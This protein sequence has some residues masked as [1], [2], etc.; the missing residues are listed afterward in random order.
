M[1]KHSKKDSTP[2]Q[3]QSN[4]YSHVFFALSD[5]YPDIAPDI[6]AV[7]P[8]N[9][10]LLELE[11]LLLKLSEDMIGDAMLYNLIEE[12]KKWAAENKLP[13]DSETTVQSQPSVCKFF[14]QGRCKF[15]EK[16]KNAHPST[17]N[18]ELSSNLQVVKETTPSG[19]GLGNNVTKEPKS[20]KKSPMKTASD[21]ISRIQWDDRIDASSFSI[22][23]LDRLD[24]YRE[25]EGGGGGV[26]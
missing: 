8:S 23:Y 3:S 12:A 14:L 11:S 26:H 25:G 2:F 22:G 4:I 9:D 18:E 5:G 16:C 21:V 19:D 20:S 7:Q 6:K 24:Y 13:T 10:H 1:A 17:N 15:G